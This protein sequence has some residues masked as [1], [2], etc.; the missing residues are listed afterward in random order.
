MLIIRDAQKKVLAAAAFET[1]LLRHARR[2]FSAECSRLGKAGTIRFL[3]VLTE[4]ARE[5]GLSSPADIAGYVD[6]AMTFGVDFERAP[7]AAPIVSQANG[8]W[9]EFT[10]DALV[11]AGMME[12]NP[13]QPA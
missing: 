13:P 2:Y 12:L 9:N 8:R 10:I 7:W 11:E 1:W 3:K 5:L 6:L 4:R